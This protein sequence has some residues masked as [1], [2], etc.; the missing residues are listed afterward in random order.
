MYGKMQDGMKGELHGFKSEMHKAMGADIDVHK[1]H[2]DVCLKDRD[3]DIKTL[4]EASN[5]CKAKTD[6]LEKGKGRHTDHCPRM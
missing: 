4:L 3:K 2:F 5:V 6:M 1:S